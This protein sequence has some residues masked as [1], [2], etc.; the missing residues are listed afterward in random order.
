MKNVKRLL[1]IS[2]VVATLFVG[3]LLL[4]TI[5][6]VKGAI[7]YGADTTPVSNDTALADNATSHGAYAG[8]VTEITLTGFTTTN[9]WQG[10]FGNVSGTIQLADSSDNVMYNWSVTSPEGEV[11]A[12]TN[13]S[14]VWTNIQCFNFSATGTM[15][16]IEAGTRGATSQV[17]MNLT[18]LE[19]NFNINATD[20]DGVNET[21]AMNG[22]LPNNDGDHDGFFVNNL[23]FT[24]GEC[25][26]T[27]VLRQ[28]TGQDNYFEEVLLWEPTTDS[29]VFTSLLEEADTAGFDS[30][31]HD[32][33]MLVL[34]DGH[35]TD[36]DTTT[37]YF[38]VEIE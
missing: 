26:S 11:F 9:T 34:E 20:E 3:S 2:L 16:G 37:Y 35:G 17:G 27:N 38:Y 21:F 12:S 5:P 10:Y 13:D 36:V 23:E 1:S 7:P 18:Q 19:A 32:F 33:Q 24:P 22:Q 25:L 6:I 31:Y 15:V 14:L 28:G 30:A 8:N 4:M 29:V